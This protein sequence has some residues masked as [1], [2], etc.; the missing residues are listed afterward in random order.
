MR[1]L[2]IGV[3]PHIVNALLITSIFSA[4]NA[5]FYNA[6]RTLYGLALQSR[7]PKIFMKTTKNGVPLPAIIATI[8]FPLLS[9]M[10]LSKG[11][12]KVLG[13]L[14]NLVTAGGI[15]NF[16]VI[17][18]TY[19]SFYRACKAQGIDRTTLPY[20]GWGQPYCGYIATVL[21]T[22]IVI[23]YGYTSWLKWTPDSFF[24]YYTMLLVAPLTFGFWKIFKKTRWLRPEE[25]DLVW[26][27]PIIDAYEALSE[28]HKKTFWR[29]IAD[30]F[31]FWRKDKKESGQA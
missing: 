6:T 15:I 1:N 28:E 7:A 5:L 30:L 25:V 2:S 9:L 13:W 4:G 31:L 29:E 26:E 20:T 12:S 21:Q 17:G 22:L 23:F 24:T 14:V 10:S 11:S 19:I 27:A 18:V 8:V 16:I 3:L